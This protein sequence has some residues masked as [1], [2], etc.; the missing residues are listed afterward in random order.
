MK[1]H[2]NET[3]FAALALAFAL[4][5]VVTAHFWIVS[6]N[7]ARQLSDQTANRD[8]VVHIAAMEF[9][10]GVLAGHSF[11]DDDEL[12]SNKPLLLLSAADLVEKNTTNELTHAVCDMVMCQNAVVLF[13]AKKAEVAK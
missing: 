11:F 1:K 10:N 6:K 3:I 9:E 2:K 12:N 13:S 8:Y 5:A 4:H 7:Q